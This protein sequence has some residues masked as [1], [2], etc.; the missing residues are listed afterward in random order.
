MRRVLS[1]VGSAALSLMYLVMAV[2]LLGLAVADLP[3]S[4]RAARNEGLPGTFTT[5]RKECRPWWAKGG[6]CT[7]FGDF[8]SSDG[9]VRLTDV[10][11]EGDSGEVGENV[12]AQYV[13]TADRPSI[14]GSDSNEWVFVAALG[15]GA[16]GYLSW[17]GWR[18]WRAWRGWRLVRTR[19]RAVTS[20][21]GE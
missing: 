7:S 21:T 19:R 15:L 12:P 13:G 11:F 16:A 18:G 14:H 5:I 6:G 9:K 4:L 10:P 8:T 2:F 20:A 1:R 3:D 17:R